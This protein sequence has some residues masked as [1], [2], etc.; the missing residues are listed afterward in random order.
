VTLVAERA[1]EVVGF[2][3]VRLERSPDPMLR[4]VV[5][6]HVAELAV[7]AACRSQGIGS[8]LLQA[9]EEWGR[10]QGAAFA[11]VEYHVANTRAGAFY[12]QR[13]GYEVA[14]RA[15]IKRLTGR[16]RRR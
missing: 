16:D 4:D 2:V 8:R 10:R 11:A 13:M 3:D 5:Y 9:A 14:S 15:A 12:E 6:C 1:S 7:A